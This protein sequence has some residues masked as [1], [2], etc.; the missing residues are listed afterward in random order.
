MLTITVSIS[1]LIIARS[2]TV[3]TNVCYL[4]V[5]AGRL[6]FVGRVFGPPTYSTKSL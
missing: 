2:S 1:N 6:G 3:T 4:R 5:F